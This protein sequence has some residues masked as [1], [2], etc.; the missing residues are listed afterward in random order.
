MSEYT[1]NY[2]VRGRAE[3]YVGNGRGNT[4]EEALQDFMKWATEED[5]EEIVSI[6]F[7]KEVHSHV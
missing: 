4:P 5:I 6:E 3:M 7:Y 2:R 1:I